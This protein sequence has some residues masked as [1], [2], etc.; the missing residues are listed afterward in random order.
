MSTIS[1]GAA[2][3]RVATL[4]IRIH[5]DDNLNAVVML[6]VKKNIDILFL[7]DTRASEYRSDYYAEQLQAKLYSKLNKVW[8]ICKNPAAPIP[9]GGKQLM[10]GGQLAITGH[11]M[12]PYLTKS[13]WMQPNKVQLCT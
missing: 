13:S 7:Q 2:D 12:R 9:S 5:A 10:V 6:I 1:D 11:R 8:T 3:L 4:N